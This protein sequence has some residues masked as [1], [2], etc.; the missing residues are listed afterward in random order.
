VLNYA[1]GT[2]HI[3]AWQSW[4]Y[5]RHTRQWQHSSAKQAVCWHWK[6]TPDGAC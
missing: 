6:W 1:L 5:F 3:V 4:W 2:G